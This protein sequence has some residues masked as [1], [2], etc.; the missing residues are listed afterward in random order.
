MLLKYLNGIKLLMSFFF[1]AWT[2][3]HND[4]L[5]NRISML[6]VFTYPFMEKYFIAGK[7][8]WMSFMGMF[9]LWNKSN[10]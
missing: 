3:A 1:L 5:P 10:F 9:V 4:K 8:S 2:V 7:L 6:W